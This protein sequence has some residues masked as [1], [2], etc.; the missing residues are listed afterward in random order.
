M[1]RVAP[2]SHDSGETFSRCAS[3]IRNPADRAAMLEVRERVVDQCNTYE[4]KATEGDLY[5]LERLPYIGNITGTML[6]DNYTNR[7]ARKNASTREIYDSIKLLP[8]NSKCPY[9]NSGTVETIDHF[10][11]KEHYP[12]HSVHPKNLIGCCH[13]CNF[14]KF[15]YF[16]RSKDETFIHPY[17][18]TIEDTIW[19]EST[20]VETTP[21]VAIYTVKRS[22]FEDSITFRR[23][24]FQFSLLKL[25]R[26][27][28]YAAADEIA[29]IEYNIEEIFNNSGALSVATHL[30]MQAR[31]RR[32]YVSNSWQASLY[33]ALSSSEWYCNGGFRIV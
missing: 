24:E 16:P 4:Q 31:S 20:I 28:S 5:L 7:L 17:F 9:C 8:R 23:V 12:I 3:I 11:P 14:N 25:D 22:A 29:S 19:L 30:S 21:P 1:L 27:Y 10:L 6:Q 15:R 26:I 33:D 2:P 32:R 13:R 18:D